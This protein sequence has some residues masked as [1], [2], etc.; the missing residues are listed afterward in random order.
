MTQVVC[1][2][3]KCNCPNKYDIVDILNSQLYNLTERVDNS[4]CFPLNPKL[5][6]AESGV[7]ADDG[8]MDYFLNLFDYIIKVMQ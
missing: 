1:P 5:S 4:T 6:E 8:I 2:S 3:L 7:K